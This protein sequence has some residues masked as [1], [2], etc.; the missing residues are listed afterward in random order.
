MSLDMSIL[1]SRLEEALF[2]LSYWAMGEESL[3][4]LSDDT[5]EAIHS[6]LPHVN[7]R[8]FLA[9]VQTI[10]LDKY[11]DIDEEFNKIMKLKLAHMQRQVADS[12]YVKIYNQLKRLSSPEGESK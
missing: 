4:Q 1:N 5:I 8:L 3:G 12:L 9:L 2:E 7:D 11:R 10:L 6:I